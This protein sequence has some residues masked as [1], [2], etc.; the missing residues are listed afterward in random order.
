MYAHILVPLD[1]SDTAEQALPH[2][3]ALAELFDAKLTL[4]RILEPLPQVRGVSPSSSRSIKQQAR[5]WAQSYFERI[6]AGLSEQGIEVA[7]E[8]LEGRPAAIITQYAGENEA[9]LIVLCSKGRSGVSRWLIGGVADRVM[10]GA[11]V[12]VLL[13]PAHLDKISAA[14]SGE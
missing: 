10:R 13:V 14:A 4:L 7:S 12:P 11:P 5:E 6:S 3:V 9:D 8:I 2:A 1:G